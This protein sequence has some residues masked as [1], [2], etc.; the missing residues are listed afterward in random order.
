M[1]F[2]CLPN[3]MES[4]APEPLAIPA[5]K[6]FVMGD[7]RNKSSDSRIFGLVPR[8]NILAKAFVRVLP[9]GHFGLGAGPTL[10]PDATAALLDTPVVPAI[11]LALPPALLLSHR[12]RRRQRRAAAGADAPSVL[13][14]DPARRA[15]LPVEQLLLREENAH[16]T[17]GA[18]G[19]VAAMDDV[20]RQAHREVTADRPGR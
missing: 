16:L 1:N 18:L 8:K 14:E 5:G 11:A 9:F 12:R 2:C 15:P 4:S 17:L 20:H 13:G 3:G 10:V 7:N 6:Y 19:G